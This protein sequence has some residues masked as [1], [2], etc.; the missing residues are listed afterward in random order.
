MQS[1]RLILHGSD[2]TLVEYVLWFFANLIGKNQ[3]IRDQV[4]Q[5]TNVM[6]IMKWFCFAKCAPETMRLI[7]WLNETITATDG[8]SFEHIMNSII[9]SMVGLKS[10][11]GYLVPCMYRPFF[12]DNIDALMSLSSLCSHQS[13]SDKVID[14][15]S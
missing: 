9:I 15:I 1:C 14:F 7:L 4:V 6:W 5:K 2:I 12:H 13:K 8:L 11:K 10:T 3:E